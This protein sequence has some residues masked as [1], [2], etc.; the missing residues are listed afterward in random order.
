M[1]VSAIIKTTYF[2]IHFCLKPVTDVMELR[3]QIYQ[4]DSMFLTMISQTFFIYSYNY[5]VFRFLTLI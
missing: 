3:E 5:I 2:L 4:A 1:F